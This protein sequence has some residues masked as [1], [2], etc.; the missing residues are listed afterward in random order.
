MRP[1]ISRAFRPDGEGPGRQ[2]TAVAALGSTTY[3]VAVH[4]LGCCANVASRNLSAKH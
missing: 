3:G 4:G 2:P 1:M